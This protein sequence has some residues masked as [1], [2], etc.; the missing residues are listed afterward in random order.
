MSLTTAN[1]LQTLYSPICQ[2]FNQRT[3]LCEQ[4]FRD[5]YLFDPWNTSQDDTVGMDHQDLTDSNISLILNGKRL[6][7]TPV[8]KHY[9]TKREKLEDNIASQI[10]KHYKTQDRQ[11]AVNHRVYQMVQSSAIHPLDKTYLTQFY[12]PFATDTMTAKFLAE[13]IWYVMQSQRKLHP[14]KAA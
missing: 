2:Q 13:V 1:V 14:A 8:C 11:Q 7:P 10:I 4:L 6:L 12:T 9:L 3:F 5:Y